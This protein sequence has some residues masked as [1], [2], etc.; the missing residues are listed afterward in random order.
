MSVTSLRSVPTILLGC[1]VLTLS[2][3][4]AAGESI[5]TFGPDGRP[6]TSVE[7]RDLDL[8]EPHDVR[9]FYARLQQAATAVCEFSV[10]HERRART[11]IP[12][13]WQERCFDRAVA[14]AV[15]SAN[16]AALTALHRGN[17]ELVA[18]RH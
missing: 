16:H 6:R 18:K 2:F 3:Q 7:I 14:D 10:R 13:D 9:T 12:F 17:S 4:V 8:D 5:V 15:R 1:A 11:P